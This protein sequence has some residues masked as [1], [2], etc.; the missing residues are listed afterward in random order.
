MSP[1]ARRSVSRSNGFTG[2]F[3]CAHQHVVAA[4]RRSR[5]TMKITA[6][7]MS[8][9]RN[10]T[11]SAVCRSN[12]SRDGADGWLKISVYVARTHHADPDPLTEHLLADAL[13]ERV[14]PEF[15]QR[16]DRGTGP[17]HPTGGGTDGDQISHTA[18]CTG[19]P[20]RSGAE[21]QPG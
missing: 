12:A 15:G 8:S 2:L 4:T 21:A 18:R 19:R 7:A 17:G 20:P 14:H 1:V 6:S 10:S 9:G 11:M 3:G 5:V 13:A 16:V